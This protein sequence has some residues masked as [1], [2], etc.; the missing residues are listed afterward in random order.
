MKGRM[1]YN[2]AA[3]MLAD[4]EMIK[5]AEACFIEAGW[6]IEVAASRSGKHTRELAKEAARDNIE[7]LIVAGGD[8]SA[9]QAAAGLLDSETAL[10]V[11][12]AGT[13]NVWANELR[14]P[15]LSRWRRD[16]ICRS[17]RALTSGHKQAMDIGMCGENPFLLWAGVGL[18]A[19][20]VNE[21][22][23][24]RKGRRQF[25][26]MR[27]VAAGLRKA[28]IWK[29]IDVELEV[30]GRHIEG[31]YLVAV[32]SNIRSYAGGLSSISP[33]AVVDDGEMELWLFSGNS[34]PKALRHAWD[35]LS[36]SHV[37]SKDVEFIQF[38]RLE[39]TTAQ[40][41]AWQLDGE[42]ISTSGKTSIEVMPLALP[43]I[44]PRDTPKGI[45]S[46]PSKA[47]KARNLKD[48]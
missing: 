32:I 9:S 1:V 23:T 2:P 18:D 44:V 20:I 40:S 21:M 48:V 4:E 6:R 35:L 17:V 26:R 43:V 34:M 33:Q 10:A 22:E 5:Q 38:R 15:G 24:R 16:A 13:A 27:Y 31:H 30:D 39:I 11:L 37:R 12:P 19:E 46:L 14:T 3:G 47:V 8:G 42:P 29:G 25:A 36:G 41:L 28:A 7:V 45:F